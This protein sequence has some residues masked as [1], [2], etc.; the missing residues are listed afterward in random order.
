MTYWL[1]WRN[2]KQRA[3]DERYEDMRQQIAQAANVDEVEAVVVTIPGLRLAKKISPTHV[4][5]LLFE[6]GKRVEA[7]RGC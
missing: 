5:E 7:I 2:T 1:A 4:R 3:Q 6:A